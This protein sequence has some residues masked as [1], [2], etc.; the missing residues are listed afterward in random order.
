MYIVNDIWLYSKKHWQW[1]KL[2][3]VHNIFIIYN[4]TH[5]ISIIYIY[6]ILY[7]LYII[8]NIYIVNNDIFLTTIDISFHRFRPSATTPPCSCAKTRSSWDWRCRWTPS[9]CTMR[10]LPCAGG[11]FKH[12][13]ML[14]YEHDV[15]MRYCRSVHICSH[16]CMTIN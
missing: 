14:G 2:W 3:Y 4:L 11:G 5:D 1:K 15:H 9:P 13:E 7:I 16:T 6:I 12:R 8:Y 10:V